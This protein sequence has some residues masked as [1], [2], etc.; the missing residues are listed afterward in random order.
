MA[1]GYDDAVSEL[2]QAPHEAF[3]TERT[4]LS[5]ELK[6]Q[7]EN[8]GG[9]R[10]A[11][12]RRP[13]LS[14]WVVNQLWLQ[15]RE[16]FEELFATAERLRAGELAASAA[17]RKAVTALVGRAGAVLEAAGHP[18]T[19]ATL[20]RVTA[21]LSALAATGS[22][23]PDPPGALTGDRDPPGFGAAGMTLPSPVPGSGTPAPTARERTE[24]KRREQEVQQREQAL[25]GAE[26]RRLKEQR[27]KRQAERHRL[28]VALRAAKREAAAQAG[29]I[30]RLGR[31]LAAAEALLKKERER[32]EELEARLSE[33][34][35]QD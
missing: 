8:A 33:L 34:E 7:G 35:S 18:A 11:K 25:A 17:H 6:A 24:A 20:R 31:E 10:L 9:A 2:Y 21:T 22:F 27:A 32:I 13:P 5:A 1:K 12:L 28:E 30:E 19:E 23:D 16:A 15:A 14:A 3:V 29:K 4:R 26:R